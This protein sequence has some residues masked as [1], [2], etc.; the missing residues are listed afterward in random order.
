MDDD[1]TRRDNVHSAYGHYYRSSDRRSSM[2]DDDQDKED[3]Q[4]YDYNYYSDYH[5]NN[6]IDSGGGYA[7]TFNWDNNNNNNNNPDS[8]SSDVDRNEETFTPDDIIRPKVRVDSI[9][10]ILA[11]RRKTLDDILKSKNGVIGEL[12]AKR[13]KTDGDNDEPATIQ[14][15]LRETHGGILPKQMVT[16]DDI[17]NRSKSKNEAT[18]VSDYGNIDNDEN[19]DK[20]FKKHESVSNKK[21]DLDKQPRLEVGGFMPVN[22]KM[23]VA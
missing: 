16:L 17:F 4:D 15:I 22:F 20:V 8:L 14:K 1:P 21:M 10:D 19:N 7:Q 13:G 23:Q 6:R 11:S 18:I 3:Y 12:K 2:G 5:A 9:Q